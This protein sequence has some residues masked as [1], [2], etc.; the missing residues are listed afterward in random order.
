MEV[1]ASS[2]IVPRR[3]SEVPISLQ[4]PERVLLKRLIAPTRM[5]QL[6]AD[7]ITRTIDDLLTSVGRSVTT[8]SGSF[9]MTFDRQSKLAEA[10]YELSR[11]G[12]AVDEYRRQLDWVRAD[13]DGGATLLVPRSDGDRPRLRL[14]TQNTIYHLRAFR[15]E[16]VALWD[17]AVCQ[18]MEVRNDTFR[19]GDA[20]AHPLM[21][22]V[23][24]AGNSR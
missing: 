19:I 22:A 18:D 5:D 9:V 16:G 13:L 20:E 12:I 10:V 3:G 14:V 21:H 2:E 7:S 23:V 1:R 6:D 4:I 17:L 8:P 24:V 15:D 11:G